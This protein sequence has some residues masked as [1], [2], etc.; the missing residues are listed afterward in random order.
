MCV[1]LAGLTGFEERTNDNKVF[2][3]PFAACKDATGKRW[4]ITGW[5]LRRA[6]GNPPCP[7]LHADPRCPTARRASRGGPRVAVVLRRHGHRG[8]VKAVA[9]TRVRVSR[10]PLSTIEANVRT[11]LVTL[12]LASIL[13]AEPSSRPSTYSKDGWVCSLAIQ[14]E[15]HPLGLQLRPRRQGPADRGLLDRRMGHGEE[16]LRPDEGTRANVVRVHLQFGKFMAA[17]DK[18]NAKAL[19]RLG[20][21]LKLAETT[22]LYLDLTGLGCYHKADVPAWYDKLVEKERWAAQAKFW[23][24]IADRCKNSPAVFCYDLMNEPVSPGGKRKDG[25]WLGPPFGDKHFVQVIALDQ[26]DRT[27][28]DIAGLDQGNSLPRSASTKG[29]PGH[30]RPRR[31][32]LGPAGPDFGFRAKGVV[33]ELDFLCVHLYPNTG[34]VDEAMTTLKGFAVGKPVVIEE[35]FPLG[36]TRSDFESFLTRSTDAGVG[37]IGFYWGVPPNELRKSKSIGDGML[38]SWLEI[39]QKR[40]KAIGIIPKE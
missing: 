17:V 29:A 8:G 31:L 15:V 35:T 40:G 28:P 13:I 27:R 23:E 20:D 26:A 14:H 24:A 2:A 30:S 34:K 16:P 6:W 22:G 21:L 4:V 39:F 3:T 32:E 38:L 18:P 37:V 36:C 19:D 12:L 33:G 9:K 1:M 11:L 7:C 10:F 5:E 25:D